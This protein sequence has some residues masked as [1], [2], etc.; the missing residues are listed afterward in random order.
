MK[1]C[2]IS[3]DLTHFNRIAFEFAACVGCL[4][5]IVNAFCSDI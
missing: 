2:L 1:Q 4:H 3:G 5:F